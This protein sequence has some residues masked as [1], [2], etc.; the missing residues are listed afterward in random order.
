[1]SKLHHLCRDCFV[2]AYGVVYPNILLME[3]V[4]DG[5]CAC[6]GQEARGFGVDRLSR[7]L[8]VDKYNRVGPGATR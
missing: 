2:G 5:I 1:M 8:V 7:D 3:P 4:A 6:C